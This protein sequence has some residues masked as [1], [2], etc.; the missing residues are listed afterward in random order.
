MFPAETEYQ[1]PQPCI[2][3][4]AFSVGPMINVGYGLHIWCEEGGLQN[5]VLDYPGGL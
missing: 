3:I 4:H 1:F 5:A 2:S